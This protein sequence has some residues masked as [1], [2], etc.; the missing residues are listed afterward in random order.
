MRDPHR[1]EVVHADAGVAADEVREHPVGGTGVGRPRATRVPRAEHEVG[2]TIDHGCDKPREI[3]GIERRI[4]VH[5][6][7]DVARRGEQSGVT[8]GAEAAIDCSTTRAP[9]RRAMLAEPSV[10]PLSTTIGENPA[11]KSSSTRRY[12]VDFVEDRK[13]DIDH[14]ETVRIGT[15]RACGKPLTIRVTRFSTGARGHPAPYAAPMLD[16]VTR[17]APEPQTR[18]AFRFDGFVVV[19]T[20]TVL[21]FAVN[22]WGSELV[23]SHHVMK[24]AFSPV[25]RGL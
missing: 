3:A 22:R 4:A 20:L 11:G 15:A 18:R 7:N 14:V 12:R 6:A 21:A 8:R 23:R 16:A 9:L 5:E 2:V 24:V 13:N 25:P 1:P 17:A 10:D 19:A